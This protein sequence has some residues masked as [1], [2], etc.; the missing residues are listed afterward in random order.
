MLKRFSLLSIAILLSICLPAQLQMADGE[1]SSQAATL[2]K[3]D[4]KAKYGAF[5]IE[6][7]ID[8]AI[9]KGLENAPVVTARE[10]GKVEMVSMEAKSY[11]GYLLPYNNFVKLRDYDFEIFYRNNFKSQKYPPERIS[12]TDESIFF[13]D[14]FGMFYGFKAEESGQRSRFKYDYEYT[15]AKYL[16]RV[17][18]HDQIPVKQQVVRFKVPSWLELEI[19]EKNFANYKIKKEVKKDK[20]FTVYTYTSDNTAGIRQEPNSLARPYYLPHLVITVRNFIADNKKINGFQSLDDMYAWYNLLY[21]KAKNEPADLKAQ[22]SQLIAGKATEEEKIKSIYYW[23]QDNIRYIAFEEGYSGFVPQTVQE[24]FKN[25]Y[26]DCKGMANIL[27]EMLKLAGFDAH[28]SWVGTREIPYDRKEIQSMCVDNHAITVLYWKGK[29]YFLD[30]TE[31]FAAFGRNAY[32]IQGKNVLVQDGDKYKVE[33]IPVPS[34]DEN[35]IHTK[36]DLVLK[37][38]KINGHVKITFDG[39]SRN[40]FHYVYNNIPANKR[41][42]FVNRM[43]ELNNV[44]A[45]V[46]NI[47]TSDFK[48][49]DIPIVLEGDVEIVNQVTKAGNQLYTSVDFF[50]ETITSSIPGDERQN[51]IDLDNVFVSVDEISLQLPANLKVAVLPKNFQAAFQNNGLDAVYSVS[52]NTILLK[53]KFKMGS[54]VI[55]PSDFAGWKEF[56]GKVRE[57]NRQNISLT[58]Q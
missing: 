5:L 47:K 45:E 58:V 6:K 24:V 49:R 9:G 28:F 48:N 32:R 2:K 46:S 50:P 30:G 12:L 56:L 36:A 54:P 43:V 18:F 33:I 29:T 26:S 8:F 14:N 57:F 15:D 35:A 25:K 21:N 40:Y 13:D 4:K 52:G 38:D 23:V 19:I 20:G 31:K 39:E 37:G 41:K 22:V 17:F 53:K 42:E 34:M 11:V 55:Y 51:P 1:G 10:K 7:E 16:T 3:I 44:N 27:A